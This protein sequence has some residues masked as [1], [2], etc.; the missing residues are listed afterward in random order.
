MVL[1]VAAVDVDLVGRGEQHSEQQH[2]DLH[3][4]VAAVHEVAVEH[5]RIVD[6]GKT[7]LF[8]YR[9]R[10]QCKNSQQPSGVITQIG[11]CFIP[12]QPVASTTAQRARLYCVSPQ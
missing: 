1:V 3:R 2:G 10:I 8:A 6:A 7:I 12:S 9:E 5:V 4:V 11:G